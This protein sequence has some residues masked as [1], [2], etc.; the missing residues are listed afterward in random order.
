MADEIIIV[1]NT[2]EEIK[3]EE[4]SGAPVGTIITTSHGYGKTDQHTIN[5]I[6]GLK[7]TLDN[8]EKLKPVRSNF[9]GHADYYLWGDTED[10]GPGYFVR[11][12]EDGMIYKC[13]NETT[14]ILGVTV[15]TAGFI[16]NDK[17]ITGTHTSAKATDINQA[18][19]ATTGVA[20]VL[21]MHDVVVG[22]YVFPTA[23]GL[24]AK[25]TGS[26]GY[27][28]T[29]LIQD[30]M[31]VQKVD[32]QKTLYARIVLSQSVTNT[33][34]VSDNVDYLLTET[35]RINNNIT[36]FGNTAEAALKRAEELTEA[37][38]KSTNEANQN[39]QNASQAAQDAQKYAQQVGNASQIAE[40][41]QKASSE[42]VKIATNI[43]DEAIEEAKKA[44]ANVAGKGDIELIKSLEHRL[45]D[46]T[47]GEYS[48]AY[49]L[50]YEQA[51]LILPIG[52]VFIPMGENPTETGEKPEYTEVYANDGEDITQT[53]VVSYS[54]KWTDNGWLPEKDSANVLVT[55]TPTIPS[56]DGYYWFVP[57]DCSDIKYKRGA[58]YRW[59]NGKWVE[60]AMRI[61]NTM[62]RTIAHLYHEDDTIIQSVS[63]IDDKV[64]AVETKVTET[65]AR[66][67]LVASVPTELLGVKPANY[68]NETK[69]LNIILKGE[70]DEETLTILETDWKKHAIAKGDGVHYYV[71]GQK[72]PYDVYACVVD[73]NVATFTK[74]NTI[75]YD[76][77]NFYKINIA[78]IITSANEDG[79]DIQLNANKIQ[80]NG[81]GIFQD[82]HGNITQI[83]GNYI[84]T[85][86]IKA[87]VM[88][89]SEIIGAINE[90]DDT[91][92]KINADHI[93]VDGADISLAGKNINLTSDNITIQSTN[94]SVDSSGNI[95][96]DNANISG[97]VYATGGEIGG[98]SIS[99]NGLNS[100][101][102]NVTSDYIS[103]PENSYLNINNKIEISSNS[104]SA[105]ITTYDDIDFEIKNNTGAGIKFSKNK[106]DESFTQKIY[107]T[108]H[109]INETRNTVPPPPG[110][111][112]E[113]YVDSTLIYECDYEITPSDT[114]LFNNFTYEFT[115]SIVYKWRDV[116]QETKKFTNSISVPANTQKGTLQCTLGN[117]TIQKNENGVSDFTVES[118]SVSGTKYAMTVGI[119]QTVVQYYTSNN[120]VLYSLGN[121]CPLTSAT[122]DDTG[123]LLGDASHKWNAIHAR[124]ATIIT[125]DRN[126]KKD[127]TVLTDNHE[128]FFDTLRPVTFVYK[129]SDSNRRHVGFIAQ[130]VEE[131]LSN[132]NI[133]TQDFA[134]I[135]I[136]NNTY[137]LR[138][139]EFI[140]INTSQIQ[141]L[142][143]RV[144]EQDKVIS[145]LTSRLEALE[146]KFK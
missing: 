86:K 47:V 62:S 81:Q 143:A 130:E 19:V 1:D 108:N 53:F 134:G 96:A 51:K 4:F 75:T 112:D 39:S 42:A 117:L 36:T 126:E 30:S 23:S 103:I 122:S 8:I 119:E 68:N 65:D 58:L 132:A 92:L 111:L 78:S 145:E 120:N 100:D 61:E 74:T 46:Y 16:G 116:V 32:A 104:E 136:E 82:E 9:L 26:Y 3:V 137:A 63:S 33:K 50:S 48:Q 54:Y 141:K 2:V 79:S 101:K 72:L 114:V 93:A 12:G 29:A 125:S 87:S 18:L 139:E 52:T 98:F 27:L 21:C 97:V 6:T 88:E 113:E 31:V 124:T 22:D 43:R 14:D 17:N 131:A 127:I 135:C 84:T 56:D 123:C 115:I 44:A 41:A 55:R 95:I 94:F 66:V 20:D 11:L 85:G 77:V 142:K 90:S 10:I 99:E 110:W 5:D 83:D 105:F 102:I 71:V 129:N 106:S 109:T 128:T 73:S 140:P 70:T 121:F 25:S 118:I 15:D 57:E 49:G 60:K 138:Y 91:S 80:F 45:D 146:E 24:A 35:K 64:T 107:F 76:G 59:E 89:A 38:K 69:A 40:Q 144:A 34:K 7:S 28:V 133:D 13:T 67:G 37:A